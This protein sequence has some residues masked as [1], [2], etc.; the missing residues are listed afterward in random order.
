MIAANQSRLSSFPEHIMPWQNSGLIEHQ[1]LK[2]VLSCVINDCYAAGED[3]GDS[4]ERRHPVKTI[5]S[6]WRSFRVVTGKGDFDFPR[7]RSSDKT[8]SPRRHAILIRYDTTNLFYSFIEPSIGTVHPLLQW[9][10]GLWLSRFNAVPCC[11]LGRMC[12]DMHDVITS[13]SWE[14][15]IGPISAGRM[16]WVRR[17]HPMQTLKKT[18]LDIAN[19]EESDTDPQGMIVESRIETMLR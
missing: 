5:H 9:H 15:K 2:W 13:R 14:I 4:P 3:R 11:P 1:I 16:N 19:T 18:L 10:L 7:W 6:A 8:V 17:L 12:G